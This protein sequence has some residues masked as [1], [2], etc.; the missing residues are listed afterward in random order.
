MAPSAMRAAGAGTAKKVGRPKT[1]P[2]PWCTPRWSAGQ[3]HHVPG[4]VQ[5]IRVYDVNDGA[6][7]VVERDPGP[8]L[9]T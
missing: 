4:T 6:N 8:V 9:P 1:W 5:S 2:K 3:G 7:H